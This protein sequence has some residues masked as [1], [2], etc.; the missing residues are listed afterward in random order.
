DHE[1]FGW[2]VIGTQRSERRVLHRHH[3]FIRRRLDAHRVPRLEQLHTQS[4]SRLSI[5]AYTNDAGSRS[6]LRNE[7]RRHDATSAGGSVG[8]NRAI[9]WSNMYV[10]PVTT[11]PFPSL[12]GVAPI[13]TSSPPWPRRLTNV[14]PSRSAKAAYRLLRRAK[15]VFAAAITS[16]TPN[17][18]R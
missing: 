6:K 16:L 17:V 11:V 4:D 15:N 12:A 2:L 9:C 10:D 8:N 13:N 5:R 7:R 3:G 14:G 18:V 1:R